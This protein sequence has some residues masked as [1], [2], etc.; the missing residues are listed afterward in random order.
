MY[1]LQQPDIAVDGMY[2]D[3]VE[4]VEITAP[5]S[6]GDEEKNGFSRRSFANGVQDHTIEPVT[7]G[8]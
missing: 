2:Y 5:L 3:R 6:D 1:I 4:G 7:Q 8:G